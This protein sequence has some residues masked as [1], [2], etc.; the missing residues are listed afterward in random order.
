MIFLGQ[1]CILS[2]DEYWMWV[3]RRGMNARAERRFE[4]VYLQRAAWDNSKHRP[5]ENST[6]AATKLIIDNISLCLQ[7]SWNLLYCGTHQI[8]DQFWTWIELI[9]I[10]PSLTFLNTGSKNIYNV[11][12]FI[13]VSC[14]KG[15]LHGIILVQCVS[16]LGRLLIVGVISQSWCRSWELEQSSAEEASTRHWSVNDN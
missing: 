7:V 6:E 13:L 5:T 1:I 14:R 9:L 4:F 10:H 11:K 12:I 2:R 8:L 16:W 15:S 3:P